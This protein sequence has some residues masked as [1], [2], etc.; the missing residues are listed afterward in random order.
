VNLHN[1]VRGQTEIGAKFW[2]FCRALACVAGV[3]NTKTYQFRRPFFGSFFGRTKKEQQI[4]D[5][6]TLCPELC[7]LRKLINTSQAPE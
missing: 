2:D 5:G 6:F 1:I 3:R 7:T 4:K